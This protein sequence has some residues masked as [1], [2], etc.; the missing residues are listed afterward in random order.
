MGKQSK[1]KQQRRTSPSAPQYTL[2][3]EAPTSA[4]AWKRNKARE[5]L[6]LPSGNVALVRR[7]GPEAFMEQ[8]IMPDA[9]API[10]QKAIHDKKG[11]PPKALDK[12]VEKPEMMGQMV[13]MMDRICVYAVIEPVVKMPPGC[14]ICGEQ[15]NVKSAALHEDETLVD[16]HLF[17][18]APRDVEALYVDEVDLTDKIFIMNYCVGGTSD[19]ERFRGEHRAAVGSMDAQ[20][21]VE[22]PTE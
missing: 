13:E 9:L 5:S 19:L 14:T 1:T 12:V 11:L 20:P 7:V 18:E 17:T 2:T 16:Y 21:G 8:G 15:D 4:N 3:N 6:R 22:G 10:V